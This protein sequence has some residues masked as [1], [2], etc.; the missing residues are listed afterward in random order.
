MK[1]RNIQGQKQIQIVNL[2][3]VPD[4]NLRKDFI[5]KQQLRRQPIQN[6]IEVT[7][8]TPDLNNNNQVLVSLIIN[9]NNN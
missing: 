8:Q 5:R 7:I 6:N 3:S 2:A 1:D 4:N 9:I